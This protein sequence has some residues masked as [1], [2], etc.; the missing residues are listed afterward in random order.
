M[1]LEAAAEAGLTAIV[2]LTE[3]SSFDL[4]GVRAEI[5]G[6]PVDD[7]PAVAAGNVWNIGLT[8]ADRNLFYGTWSTRPDLLL[9]DLVS[10]L[11]PDL[12]PDHTMSVLE[13]P[14]T[15]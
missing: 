4:A 5:T 8:D 11:H 12:L 7:F 3:F 1:S 14:T 13:P 6:L 9:E 2:W 15:S 10:I